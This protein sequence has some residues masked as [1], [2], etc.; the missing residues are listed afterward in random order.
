MISLMWGSYDI[1]ISEQIILV[2]FA[3]DYVW[4]K[5]FCYEYIVIEL[6]ICVAVC[7][8]LGNNL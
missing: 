1:E 5:Y 2:N 3:F 7:L 6:F 4:T 8:L